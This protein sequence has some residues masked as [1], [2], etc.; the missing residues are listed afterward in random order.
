MCFRVRV[1]VSVEYVSINKMH[2]L[3]QFRESSSPLEF[4]L[5]FLAHAGLAFILAT[6]LVLAGIVA[7]GSDQSE[8]DI[9]ALSPPATSGAT[10]DQPDATT[11][12]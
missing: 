12:G 3:R 10:V 1:A 4:G 7:R 6:A 8:R 5:F 11:Q 9:G 2:S